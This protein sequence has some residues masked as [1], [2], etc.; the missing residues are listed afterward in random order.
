MGKNWPVLSVGK[1]A[2]SC[3]CYGSARIIVSK[4]LDTYVCGID[5]DGCYTGLVVGW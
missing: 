2:S 5:V 4:L 1:F 3:F